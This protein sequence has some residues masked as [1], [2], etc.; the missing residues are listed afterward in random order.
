MN[1]NRM[2]ETNNE[3]RKEAVKETATSI[4]RKSLSIEEFIEECKYY[5]KSIDCALSGEAIPALYEKAEEMQE[6]KI[7]LTRDS[8]A[9]LIEEAADRA[10]K[11]KMFKEQKL[12]FKH[13]RKSFYK[14]NH[15]SGEMMSISGI[16]F[17]FSQSIKKFYCPS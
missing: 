8:A 6:E 12:P 7:L 13:I 1:K 3:T 4:N 11:P 10:E 16:D 2:K 14:T 5:A 9:A 17:K 15:F